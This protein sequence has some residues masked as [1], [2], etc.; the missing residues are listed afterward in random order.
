MEH[1]S[2]YQQFDGTHS[3]TVAGSSVYFSGAVKMLGVTLDQTLSFD[4]HVSNVVSS[5]TYHTRALRHIKPLITISAAKMIASSVVGARLDY[6]N[7]LLFGTNACNLDHLQRIQNTLA[8]A[9]LQKPF[10]AHSTEL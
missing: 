3:I 2:G 10:S 1:G 6:C 9:V 4:Q 5:C 7:S 8:R